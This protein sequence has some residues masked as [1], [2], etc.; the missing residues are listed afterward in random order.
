V[1]TMIGFGLQQ[2]EWCVGEH[3]VVAPLC[4]E[5]LALDVCHDVVGLASRTVHTVL[6][7]PTAASPARWTSPTTPPSSH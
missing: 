2:S 7:P 4:G 6:R 3:G 1:P 5:Q